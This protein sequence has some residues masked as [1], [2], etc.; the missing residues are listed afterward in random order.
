MTKIKNP[1]TIGKLVLELDENKEVTFELKGK[2][3]ELIKLMSL[4]MI[5]YDDFRQIV[6]DAMF[7][8]VAAHMKEHGIDIREVM[9]Q[10]AHEAQSGHFHSEPPMPKP[11]KR[12]VN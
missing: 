9:E 7:A 5:E 1:K 3:T 11:K 12:T 4:T 10:A 6:G 8:L 2:K